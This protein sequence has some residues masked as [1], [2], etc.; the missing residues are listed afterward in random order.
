MADKCG[1]WNVLGRQG[2]LPVP[3]PH[4]HCGEHRSSSHLVEDVPNP[5]QGVAI[6]DCHRVDFSVIHTKPDRSILLGDKEDRASPRRRGWSDDSHLE[7]LVNFFVCQMPLPVGNLVGSLMNWRSICVACH[8]VNFCSFQRAGDSKYLL[9]PLEQLVQGGFVPSKSPL[10]IY[11]TQV[12][13][14][15]DVWGVWVNRVSPDQLVIRQGESVFV[16]SVP[17]HNTVVD[18]IIY[19]EEFHQPYPRHID[20]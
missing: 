11:R 14:G 4:V 15:P 19:N 9:E 1:F 8:R 18:T 10:C 12:S 16:E 3:R 17:A 2:Y 20:L 7:H 13:L 6:L 5:W